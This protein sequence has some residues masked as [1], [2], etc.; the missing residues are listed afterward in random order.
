M[1]SHLFR[2]IESFHCEANTSVWSEIRAFIRPEYAVL[3][4]GRD[5]LDHHFT[6][7][8]EGPHIF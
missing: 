4:C 3:E 6:S 8:L 2:L 7:E 1:L 5:H